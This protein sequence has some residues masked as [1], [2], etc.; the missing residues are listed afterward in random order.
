MKTCSQREHWILKHCHQVLYWGRYWERVK[1]ESYQTDQTEVTHLNIPFLLWALLY[2]KICFILLYRITYFSVMCWIVPLHMSLSNLYSNTPL[3]TSSVSVQNWYNQPLCNTVCVCCELLFTP[4]HNTHTHTSQ[5]THAEA[6]ST[7]HNKHTHACSALNTLTH[8]LTHI[9]SMKWLPVWWVWI[10]MGQGEA[11][12]LWRREDSEMTPSTGRNCLVCWLRKGA[13][14]VQTGGV[15]GRGSGSKPPPPHGVTAGGA[16]WMSREG[17]VLA[18]GGES[19][20]SSGANPAMFRY[21][22]PTFRQGAADRGW[23]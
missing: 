12:S 9:L 13:Q 11:L 17:W 21:L 4:V 3:S 15:E 18:R 16:S 7:A 1:R 10:F 22:V 20:D 19:I 23:S 14:C 2:K 8:R 6:C 5:T